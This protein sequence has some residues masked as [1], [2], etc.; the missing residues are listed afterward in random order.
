MFKGHF[1]LQ[2]KDCQGFTD[3]DF[4]QAVE[5]GRI[6]DLLKGLPLEERLRT[7]NMIFSWMAAHLFQRLFSGGDVTDPW[8]YGDSSTA[9][10][11]FILLMTTDSEPSYTEQWWRW[12]SYAEQ[13]MAEQAGTVEA[14]TA[15]KRFE[16]DQISDWV[17]WQDSDGREAVHFRNRWLYTPS[18][19]NS[20]TIRS[21]GIYAHTD[22][23]DTYRD[24]YHFMARSGRV[25]LKDTG[26][27]PVTLSKNSNQVLLVEYTITMVS[28]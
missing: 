16:E 2:L 10:F 4:D 22:G 8:D 11:A 27:N 13:Y 21:L 26:G 7:D 23:D 3:A 28:M 15:A 20:S 14:S 17:I 12:N 5:E 1:D 19:A 25:R 6:D 9:Y 24:Y 18:Q